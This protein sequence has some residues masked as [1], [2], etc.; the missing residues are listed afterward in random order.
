MV[1]DALDHPPSVRRDSGCPLVG[2]PLREER[3]LIFDLLLPSDLD[4]RAP[5]R[6]VNFPEVTPDPFLSLQE[7]DG[8]D[9]L[10]GHD[11][12]FLPAGLRPAS[13]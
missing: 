6:F 5:P 4:A 9:L 8:E 12:A 13:S 11:E 2:E 10:T 7:T 1:P 3:L